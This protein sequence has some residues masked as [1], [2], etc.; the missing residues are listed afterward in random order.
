MADPLET[1]G[2]LGVSHMCRSDSERALALERVPGP[3][4]VCRVPDERC[5]EASIRAAPIPAQL[6][7]HFLAG[8]SPSPC[9]A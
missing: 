9:E 6:H 8:Q 4:K 7:P 2:P 5:G 1:S 3:S